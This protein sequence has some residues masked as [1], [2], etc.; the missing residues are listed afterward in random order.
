MTSFTSN[1]DMNFDRFPTNLC[2]MFGTIQRNPISFLF[3]R[4]EVWFSGKCILELSTN[5]KLSGKINN[6]IIEFEI[7]NNGFSNQI[8]KGFS[9][10]EISTTSNRIIWS[11]DIQNRKNIH[12]E[13]LVPYLVSLFFING[14]LVKAA[15][16]IHNQNTMVELYK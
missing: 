10:E 8:K 5:G 1:A 9:F 16:N 12:Y 3:S 4:V 7:D 13:D 2:E 6:D 14:E 15:F 11:K